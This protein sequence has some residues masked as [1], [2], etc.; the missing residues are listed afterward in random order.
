MQPNIPL[1]HPEI[2]KL[3][4]EL[5]T[6][7]ELSGQEYETAKRI[8]KFA[9]KHAHTARIETFGKTA[10]AIIY[11]FSKKGKTIAIRC[12]LD[13]LPIVEENEFPHKSANTGVSHKCGH[14]GH[15]A[16]VSGLVFWL[17]TQPIQ[18]GKVILLFQPA[19]ETGKGAQMLVQ[20]KKFEALGIDYVFAL[21]NIPKE[22]INNIIITPKG[23]SAE[24]ISVIIKTKGKEAHAAEPENGINPALAI[25]KIIGEMALLNHTDPHLEDFAVLT[26]VHLLMGEKA[27]GI[28]PSNAELH[29]TIRTW[30]STQMSDLTSKIEALVE[31][32]CRLHKLDFNLEWLEYFPASINDT[33]CSDQIHMAAFENGLEIVQKNHPFKFGE[34]FGWYSKKYKTAMFGLGAGVD[35]PA[36]HH[37]DYDFPDEIIGAG[38]QMF[39]SII[40][41]ILK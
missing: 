21:H 41:N 36:L 12:E 15:M 22:P 18:N 29:Y 3:R 35:S 26:P 30:N 25:S 34:D 19:E 31:Q 28:S 10:I 40:Q 37:A 5:H 24:V 9:E 8:W 14:D 2:M 4:K 20:D 7:P 1:V 13:A 33:E 32:I 23:F 27:Y 16:M 38:I 17:E 39:T 11:E 6:Y